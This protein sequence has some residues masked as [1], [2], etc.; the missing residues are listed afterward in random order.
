MSEEKTYTESEAQRFFAVRYNGTTW[1]LLEKPDRTKADDELMVHTAHASCC[2]WLA[3]GTG[4]S[5]W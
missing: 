4:W 3:A 5:V 1:D 2:H